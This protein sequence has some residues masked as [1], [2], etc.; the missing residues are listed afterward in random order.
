MIFEIDY[1][2][3]CIYEMTAHKPAFKAFVSF[4]FIISFLFPV[5]FLCGTYLIHLSMLLDEQVSVYYQ[6][7]KHLSIHLTHMISS[8]YNV[9]TLIVGY[10]D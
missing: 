2:G 10:V 1:P 8:N 6:S 5:S 4:F 7:D 3:C 9:W